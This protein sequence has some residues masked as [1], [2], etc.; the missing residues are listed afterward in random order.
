M[1]YEEIATVTKAIKSIV[2]KEYE[3]LE[4][5]AS[6]AFGEDFEKDSSNFYITVDNRIVWAKHEH[7]RENGEKAFLAIPFDSVTSDMDELIDSMQLALRRAPFTKEMLDRRA[8]AGS[9]GDV[10]AFMAVLAS[11]QTEGFVALCRPALDAQLAA[12]EKTL[13]ELKALA[14]PISVDIDASLPLGGAYETHGA[15]DSL[16][17][18]KFPRTATLLSEIASL[19]P[20]LRQFV[21]SSFNK[22]LGPDWGETVRGKFGK[23]LEKWQRVADRRGGTDFLDGMQ[24]GDLMGVIEEFKQLKSRFPNTKQVELALAVILSNRPG[25]SHPI[26]EVK[27]DISVREFEEV[28]LAVRVLERSLAKVHHKKE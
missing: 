27:K 4:F 6:K 5:R 18:L 1:L 16:V 13:R 8:E 2:A 14:E 26:A 12:R 23:R 3:R 7:T 20:G 25:L 24:L 28:R 15:K 22:D 17:S 21:R 19:E 10:G 11:R 9:Q